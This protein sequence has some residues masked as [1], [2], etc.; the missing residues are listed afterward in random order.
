VRV[1]DAHSV[2][3]VQSL[4]R[5]LRA[6]Q[7]D[8]VDDAEDEAAF[9]RR[10][11]THVDPIPFSYYRACRV[12]TLVLFERWEEAI[13]LLQR[14]PQPI[15]SAGQ[16]WELDFELF[17]ALAHARAPGG[18]RIRAQ[19]MLLRL[20]WRAAGRAKG[21]PRWFDLYAT[22]A[23]AE[24]ARLLGRRT[25]ARQGFER[26]RLIADLIGHG[27]L[28]A[29]AVWY[30]AQLDTPIDPALFGD[31]VAR[32]EAYGASAVAQRMQLR[33]AGVRSSR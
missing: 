25:A 3:E 16:L 19:A 15:I 6:L 14:Y 29:C 27:L 9:A 4:E 30:D 8:A 13:D 7:G 26:A 2:Y 1:G 32:F 21:G 10:L 18:S 12:K 33:Q 24:R 28:G 20:E 22:F 23:A 17:A 31:A 11:E 5:A